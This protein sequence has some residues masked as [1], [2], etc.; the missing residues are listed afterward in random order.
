[1]QLRINHFTTHLEGILDPM[2]LLSGSL[3]SM[4]P[5]LKQGGQKGGPKDENKWPEPQS[6]RAG[7]VQTQ[8]ATF[9]ENSKY[10]RRCLHFGYLCLSLLILLS[11]LFP[12][13]R[14]RG[15]GPRPKVLQSHQ[16]GSKGAPMDPKGVKMS[17]GPSPKVLRPLVT[18]DE[19]ACFV[20]AD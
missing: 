12:K 4:K 8:F 20:A 17:P 9:H 13:S 3:A 18:A 2:A 15:P 5:V 16:N 10:H 19:V 6:D 14:Q 1:M 11:S 7:S